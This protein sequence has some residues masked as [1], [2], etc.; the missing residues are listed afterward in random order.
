MQIDEIF[1]K[2][3]GNIKV[4]G[5]EFND[6]LVL[7]NI[8]S[9]EMLLLK[10]INDMMYNAS[11][12]ASHKS[13]VQKVAKHSYNYLKDIKTELDDTLLNAKKLLFRDEIQTPKITQIGS[14]PHV[15]KIGVD[16]I[17]S[18]FTLEYTLEWYNKETQNQLTLNE[19]HELPLFKEQL[20][21]DGTKT[22]RA[23]TD[24]EKEIQYWEK[25]NAA[26]VNYLGNNVMVQPRVSKVGTIR[27][28][29]GDVY[30]L[31]TLYD[32]VQLHKDIEEP[33]IL[34]SEEW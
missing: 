7:K 5:D 1:D 3:I 27:N 29:Y 17:I 10:L 9:A 21:A 33:L 30:T 34:C 31:S 12:V 14:L 18:P 32:A 19:A 24:D 22:V 16:T 26:E 13:S 6:E 20:T 11:Q 15:Y 25:A 28:F 8:A 4:T 2:L 23:Y